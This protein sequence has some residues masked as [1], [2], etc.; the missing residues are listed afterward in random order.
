MDNKEFNKIGIK[1]KIMLKY[2]L[3][4]YRFFNYV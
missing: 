4:L 1:R 3:I 2:F